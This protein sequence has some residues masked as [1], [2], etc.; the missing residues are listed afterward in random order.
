MPLLA[1]IAVPVLTGTAT[2]PVAAATAAAFLT[3]PLFIGGAA[4]VAG[5]TALAMAIRLGKKKP[6]QPAPKL[7]PHPECQAPLD[8]DG[9]CPAWGCPSWN[10]QFLNLKL[11]DP[12]LE[13]R[14]ALLAPVCP[15][16]NEP[17]AGIFEVCPT[18]DAN[19]PT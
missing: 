7:C 6:A 3:G 13:K 9:S 10:P 1:A 4:V 18:C 5:T 14:L 2:V 15:T 11:G 17:Y 12:E 8:A 16:C 19:E